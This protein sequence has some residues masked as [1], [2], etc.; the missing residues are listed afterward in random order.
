MR[1]AMV[2]MAAVMAGPGLASAGVDNTCVTALPA[3]TAVTS[4]ASRELVPYRVHL[5]TGKVTAYSAKM[6]PLGNGYVLA[7]IEDGQLHVYRGPHLVLAADARGAEE[8]AWQ[9]QRDGVLYLSTY[10]S[11]GAQTYQALRV[12]A[13]PKLDVVWCR[14]IAN[15][16]VRGAVLTKS[17]PLV[18]RDPD[19]LT[20]IDE[21]TGAEL[22]TKPWHDN[23]G[24]LELPDA[25]QPE[26]APIAGAE[27][28]GKRWFVTTADAAS[29]TWRLDEVDPSTGAKKRIAG[30][31]E[32]PPRGMGHFEM[33]LARIDA[34]SDGDLDV[35]VAFGYYMD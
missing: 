2:V 30:G 10:F 25:V 34:W 8:V 32:A 1:L 12:D 6:P 5:A 14:P 20:G 29:G 17:G 24:P 18:V 13:L 19:S 22:W 9:L 16:Q 4:H 23:G 7:K 35:S 33:G 27:H 11:D 3:G 28:V 21:K 26:Q 31:S 15:K